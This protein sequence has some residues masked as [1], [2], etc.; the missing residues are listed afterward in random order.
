MAINKFLVDN[1]F[2]LHEG[3]INE[4]RVVRAFVYDEK[5]NFAFHHIKGDD[6]FGHRDYF[7]TPGGGVEKGESD[8]IAIKRECLEELGYELQDITFFAEVKDFYNAINRK[9]DNL[10]FVAKRVGEFKGLHHVSKGDSYISETLWIPLN[11]AL[12]LYQKSA[13]TPIAR[14]LNNREAPLIK[15]LEASFTTFKH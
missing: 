8:L 10:Y 12:C 7:E 5:G 11:K 15:E 2:L 6:L 4:R 9:N 3:V 1:E 14:L 13:T